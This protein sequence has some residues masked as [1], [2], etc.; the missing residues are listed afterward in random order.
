MR[1]EWDEIWANFAKQISRRSVDPK[2]KVGA[3]VI[4]KAARMKE[5]Q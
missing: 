4:K 5:N 2:Y 3:V 1:P